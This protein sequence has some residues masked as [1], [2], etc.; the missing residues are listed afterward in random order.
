MPTETQQGIPRIMIG[1]DSQRS[2][3]LYQFH[4][5]LSE[6]IHFLPFLAN[7]SQIAGNVVATNSLDLVYLTTLFLDDGRAIGTRD[8]DRD[9][10][11]G[12]GI[13]LVRQIREIDNANNKVPIVVS[14]SNPTGD[15]TRV[16]ALGAGVTR[17][18]TQ[19]PVEITEAIIAEL[20]KLKR[21]FPK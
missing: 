3:R 21:Y 12:N 19:E 14:M 16:E 18:T 17:L 11:F 8:T 5:T 7:G 13:K 15:P 1:Y 4:T 9:Y 6:S 20:K 2:G 10:S